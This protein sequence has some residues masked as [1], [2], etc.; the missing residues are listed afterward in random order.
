MDLVATTAVAAAAGW[1]FVSCPAAGPAAS[2]RHVVAP[3]SVTAE[4][5]A[6]ASSQSSASMGAAVSVAAGVAIMS[7]SRRRAQ[8]SASRRE[9]VRGAFRGAKI[10]AVRAEADEAGGGLDEA[11]KMFQEAYN[12]EVERSTLLKS[13]VE[14]ALVEKLKAV[15][16][17]S[18]VKV[19]FQA[20]DLGP[21]PAHG[22]SG[23]WREAFEA[24]K[25]QTALLEDQYN[26]ARTIS[27]VPPPAPAAVAATAT[28]VE[29]PQTPK[30]TQDS[31][32]ASSGQSN[33]GGPF[34]LGGMDGTDSAGFKRLEDL[35]QNVIADE[36][37][38][39]LIAVPILG[40]KKPEEQTTSMPSVSRVKEAVGTDQFVLSELVEFERVHVLRVTSVAGVN[41]A[42]GLEVV[43]KR[44][45]D[46]GFS[47]VE[48]FLQP[49]KEEGSDTPSKSKL[50]IFAMLKEDLPSVEFQWWQ[51]ALCAVLLLVTVFS[52]NITTFSVATAAVKSMD[53]NNVNDLALMGSKTVPTG[54][55]IFTT[56]AA[57]E[58]ARR[59]AAANYKVDLTPPF[60]VPT[61]PFPS[62][63]AFGAVSRRL[64]LIP[65]E[66]AALSMSV[67]ASATGLLV[68]GAILAYGLA[69]GPDPDKIVNINFQ[70]LP[71][72]LKVLLQPLLGVAAVT[73]QPDPFAAPINIAYPANPFTVG[74]II[75]LIV[76]CLNLL[77]IGRLDGGVIGKNVF[78][79]QT[80]GIISFL[81]LGLNLIGCSAPDD[82]GLLYL[83]FG[84]FV[85]IFQNGN[86]IPARDGV[87]ESNDTL[88]AIGAA[89]VVFGFAFSVP[90]LLLPNL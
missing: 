71:A 28:R 15:G 72:A 45:A 16:S 63:G 12:A 13:Q 3:A 41:P 54:I 27:S 25:K 17:D 82:S 79:G 50:L 10:T 81:A 67:A 18:T 29:T 47:Q 89:L 80:F 57:Q 4:A 8:L 51:W 90:G 44:V 53:I 39:Q 84:F 87:T 74:G 19:S 68:A 66:E 34:G 59:V 38:L 14:T 9:Q 35:A 26:K 70:L 75:S 42:D 49:S 6:A 22:G 43:R 64:S 62:V 86:E 56:V 65:K 30:P 58:I 2:S 7:A 11:E 77:P 61:W 46:A 31:G 88:K 76:V 40:R 36:A 5:P 52:V 73:D 24:V 33:D 32:S 85:I 78:G 69:M 83:T 21:S 48:L 1:S 37:A 23:T 20:P 60:F 55:A